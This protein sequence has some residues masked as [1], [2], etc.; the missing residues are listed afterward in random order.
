MVWTMILLLWVVFPIV[1]T[2]A[3]V[4]LAVLSGQY[5]RRINELVEQIEALENSQES[6]KEL[7]QDKEK[8][9]IQPLTEPPVNVP[10]PQPSWQPAKKRKNIQIHPGLAALIIGVIFVVIAG[11]IFATTNWQMI[12]DLYK[13]VMV[14][15]FA[16]LFFITSRVAERRMKIE[17]TGRAFY[18]LG[19][20][21]LFLAVLAV[22][23]FRLLGP[24]FVLE[25]PGRWWVLWAGSV[26]T[27]IAFMIGF[28][29]YR[30][31]IFTFVYLCGLT[32]SVTFL[33]AALRNHGVG[34]VNGM[35]CYAVVLLVAGYI[36]HQPEG[37]LGCG[38]LPKNASAVWKT[39]ST[40]N[41]ALSAVLM[42]PNILFGLIA[43]H[44]GRGLEAYQITPFGIL[45]VGL[46]AAGTAILAS[47]QKE[48][49]G[50]QVL[51]RAAAAVFLQYAAMG[52]PAEAEYQ[53]LL[54]AAL[55]GGWFVLGRKH[56]TWL[57][58]KTGDSILT[59]AAAVNTGILFINALWADPGYAPQITAS[60]AI[61]IFTG[62]AALWSRQYP[63]VRSGMLYLLGTLTVTVYGIC[64]NA[65]LLQIR[66][67]HILFAYVVMAAIWDIRKK[68]D[69]WVDILVMGAIPQMLFHM[70]GV[71]CSPFFLLLSLYL[72]IKANGQTGKK[73]RHIFRW[74][75]ICSLAGT[76]LE[77]TWRLPNRVQAMLAVAALLL[78]EYLITCKRKESWKHD[79]IWDVAGSGVVVALMAAFYLSGG[80]GMGY[81]VVCLV[82]FFLF[83][84]KVYLGRN[85][86]AHLPMALVMLPL[87]W[88]I[89][90]VYD[91]SE[92]QILAGTA[93]VVLASGILFRLCGP[94]HRS[95]E[96]GKHTL[97]VD[98]YHILIGPVLIILAGAGGRAWE[99]V[100]TLLLIL[101]VLQY[102]A[103]K[104]LRK[105]AL[106]VAMALGGWLWWRQPFLLIPDV[107]WL[108]MSLVPAAAFAAMLSK[109]WGET[110]AV[111]YLRT[112]IYG[113]CL[114]LMTLAAFITGDVTD[115]ILLEILCLAI[116][117]VAS[118]RDSRRWKLASGAVM[119]LVA[120]Y[121]T[122][123]FWLSLSWWVYLM[124]AGIGLIGFAAWNEMKRR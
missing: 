116:F 27:E 77:L 100:Y 46:L 67:H 85:L 88:H 57:W 12:P 55:H 7:V 94:V 82:L 120:L 90:M 106:T 15:A 74:S 83:Y 92:N 43:V 34:F 28:R 30:E 114:V 54:A 89:A 38:F 107:I 110:S 29:T 98:W 9:E 32:V 95:S 24:G 40:M 113:G 118:K 4:V 20:I 66:Y 17:R 104:S 61:L 62:M 1:G 39:F 60:A 102:A 58:T 21:F 122:R 2:M 75:C 87:P 5:K 19:S 16:G 101:Y 53:Y 45:C 37:R 50:Y 73:E 47:W 52:I 56:K 11:L 72:F 68:D 23:Y 51:Y 117:L 25:G 44:G 78:V 99:S 96:D 8:E 84:G 42:L 76:Y 105:S 59:G 6:A 80:I 71:K 123:W 63:M 91:F 41:F 13:V 36:N 115:A 121:M 93:A 109:I 31:R 81:L 112:G 70:L 48:R 3:I 86:L 65:G 10:L 22:G 111:T 69:F 26:V 103:T 49:K 64:Q 14:L 33:M 108:E 119:V 35:V 79:W 124:A 18:I 97:Q